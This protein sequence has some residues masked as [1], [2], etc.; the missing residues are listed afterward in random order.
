MDRKEAIIHFKENVA[1]EQINFTIEA[2]HKDFKSKRELF[3]KRLVDGFEQLVQMIKESGDTTPIAFVQYSFLQADIINGTYQ[4]VIEA[5]DKNHYL[6][7]KER[8]LILDMKEFFQVFE[9][10]EV[11]MKKESAKYIGNLY[12]GDI[13]PY[14]LQ[15]FQAC[16]GWFYLAGSYAYRNI[17]QNSYYQQLDKCQVFQVTLGGYMDKVQIIHVQSKLNEEEAKLSLYRAQ[18]A[19]HLKENTYIY[20]DFSNIIW[21]EEGKRVDCK[22]LMFTCF[23]GCRIRYHLFMFTNFIGANFQNSRI[24][25]SSFIGDTFQQSDFTGATLCYCDMHTSMFYGGEYVDGQITPGIYPVSFRGSRLEHVNFSY[26]D[27]R[28]CDFTDAWM[29]DVIL[30]SAKLNRAKIPAQYKE[31]LYLSETQLLEVEWV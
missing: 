4:W 24:D 9:D 29:E 27:L 26:A 30:D 19:L 12:E 1:N 25:D 18:D 20:Q 3:C 13:Q 14:K 10:M 7:K 23:Q 31:K 2:F 22:N 16:V 5:K 17:R 15:A 28:E 8:M 11:R 6:D 21:K